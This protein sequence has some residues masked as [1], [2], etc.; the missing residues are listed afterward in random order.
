MNEGIF[1]RLFEIA[2][3]DKNERH[4]Y[5]ESLKDY[6]DLK[7]AMDTYFDDGK[8][9]LSDDIIQKLTGL[10]LSEIEKL[11]NKS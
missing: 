1:K 9:G 7:S 3:M 4:V 8:E 11:R 2:K 6:W 5:Q 10:S